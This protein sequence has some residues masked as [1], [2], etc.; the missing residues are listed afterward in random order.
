MRAREAHS[1]GVKTPVSNQEGRDRI[2]ELEE[3]L[4]KLSDGDAETWTS[5]DCP[6]EVKRTNLEDNLAFESVGNGQSLFEGLEEHGVDLPPPEELNEEQSAMKVVQVA[7]ALACLRIFLV[8][9]DRMPPRECYSTL[10][11]ETLWEA[12]YVEKRNPNAVTLIDV[13]H[14]MSRSE[15]RDFLKGLERP[16]VH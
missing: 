11:N 13:S 12:C 1:N 10:W 6:A 15:M 7:R 16:S 8:G 2:R 3:E 4:N 14:S 5:P 9:F